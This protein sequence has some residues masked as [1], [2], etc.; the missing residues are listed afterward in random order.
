MSVLDRILLTLLAIVGLL[1]A[2]AL[3][4]LGIGALT[5]GSAL[6]NLTVYPGDVY[7]VVIAVVAALI[8]L[9]FLFYKT[10]RGRDSSDA[11]ILPGEHGSIRISFD[12]LKQLA[13]RTG[14]SIHGV[15]DFDTRVRNGQTG[16]VL[17]ARV[18]AI[19]DVD[20]AQ[21]STEIQGKVREYVERTSGVKVEA[22][23]VNVVEV[24][25]SPAKS[26]RTWVE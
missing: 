23:T 10:G 6:M 22:V 26:A 4:L 24:A 14:K 5:P 12:T 1:F 25:V 9:R 7:V 19:P 13:N 8:S 2:V 18:R 20:L 11:V 21:M 17:G 16:V 3:F 15:H